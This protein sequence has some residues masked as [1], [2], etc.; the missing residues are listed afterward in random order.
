VDVGNRIDRSSESG[1]T[2]LKLAT[3]NVHEWVGAGGRKKPECVIEVIRSLKADM[4]ALQEVSF[5]QKDPF[6]PTIE[7]LAD[8]L[9][10][11]PI[12]GI[13]F[14]KK[15]AEYGNLLLCHKQPDEIRLIDLSQNNREPR[16]AIL[17]RGHINGHHYLVAATHLGLS[18][19]ERRRQADI[20]LRHMTEIQTDVHILM[21]DLNEWW[22]TVR[23]LGRLY[24]FFGPQVKHRT[25]PCRMP[26]FSLDRILV[27]W[28]GASVDSCA[29]RSPLVRKVSDHLPVV[30]T[31][32]VA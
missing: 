32:S 7:Q 27:R 12:P 30:A 26:L 11:L 15:D 9:G 2:E 14:L 25:Y 10:M 24:E 3:Y 28:P 8:D 29:I 19:G 23:S 5:P 31:I 4:I 17:A 6:A 21:G 1:S 18:A 13:T 16:G 20:L 22:L